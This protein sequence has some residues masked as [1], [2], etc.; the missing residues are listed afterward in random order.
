MSPSFRSL[1]MASKE[2]KTTEDYF[3]EQ[4]E[5]LLKDK[6]FR[7]IKV[8]YDD[9]DREKIK[10][11]TR[12]TPALDPEIA[13][14]VRSM[15]W[16]C[17]SH[18]WG[19]PE[20]WVEWED[21]NV[22]DK[23]SGDVISVRVLPSKPLFIQIA[24]QEHGGY[25]WI[26]VFCAQSSTPLV[27]MG[28]IY[29]FCINCIALLDCPYDTFYGRNIWPLR[30]ATEI[31]VQNIE[32]AAY[33]YL[34]MIQKANNEDVASVSWEQVLKDLLDWPSRNNMEKT[35]ERLQ[36]FKDS[37]ATTSK[38]EQFLD[39]L[40]ELTADE[41]CDTA[42]RFF[43][44]DD[45]CEFHYEARKKLLYVLDRHTTTALDEATDHLACFLESQW[46][47]RIWTLQE[48]ALPRYCS[49]PSN[50]AG[51]KGAETASFQGWATIFRGLIHVVAKAFDFW[52]DGNIDMKLDF[53]YKH[54]SPRELL[55]RYQEQDPVMARIYSDYRKLLEPAIIFGYHASPAEDETV[56]NAY[57]RALILNLFAT[58]QRK[59]LYP[60]DYVYGVLG[61]LDI[62]IPRLEDPKE[63][64]E[65]FSNKI[66]ENYPHV[67]VPENVDL[68]NATRME[69]VFGDFA[70]NLENNVSSDVIQ[71]FS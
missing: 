16:R 27:I 10:S 8:E 18:V 59:A 30:E 69:D 36:E 22:I 60:V 29:R 11:L 51:Y 61:V 34:D 37:Y 50:T 5:C 46:M 17:L 2:L 15:G 12:V 31:C 25:W 26:D 48:A 32:E 54:Q 57:S 14:D 70:F 1:K 55:N 33:G 62:D 45:D 35:N 7:L 13:A 52:I 43:W 39:S 21:S 41:K 65:I 9:E 3:Q 71:Y 19:S 24:L 38:Q 68:G 67:H 40:M 6:H 66:R 42:R 63:I 23:E 20:D 44:G 56:N 58:S 64:W 49:A 28:S 4:Y 47:N 53:G